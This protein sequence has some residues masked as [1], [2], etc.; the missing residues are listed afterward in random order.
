MAVSSPG[1]LQHTNKQRFQLFLPLGTATAKPAFEQG[2]CLQAPPGPSAAGVKAGKGHPQGGSRC[3]SC[4]PGSWALWLLEVFYSHRC[5]QNK[6]RKKQLKPERCLL[7]RQKL[8]GRERLRRRDV[9]TDT[10]PHTCSHPPARAQHEHRT[11]APAPCPPPRTCLHALGRAL[12][13]SVSPEQ[14]LGTGPQ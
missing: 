7:S 3:S 14:Q 11:A 9:H 8:S 1:T 12:A 6:R 4:A 10:R 2:L 13:T 5:S